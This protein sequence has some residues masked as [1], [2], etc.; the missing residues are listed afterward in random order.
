[1]TL[2]KER[3]GSETFEWELYNLLCLLL[4]VKMHKTYHSHYIWAVC[5]C[6]YEKHD[7]FYP[8]VTVEIYM[9]TGVFSKATKPNSVP[10]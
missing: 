1:M 2:Y 8:F 5:V 3:W 9:A 10:I 4:S 6:K 7:H